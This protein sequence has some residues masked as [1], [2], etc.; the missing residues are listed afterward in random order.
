MRYTYRKTDK[1]YSL[2]KYKSLFKEILV[3]IYYYYTQF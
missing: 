3:D 1:M 2:N